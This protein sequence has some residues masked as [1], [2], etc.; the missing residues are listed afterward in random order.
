M[1]GS[2]ARREEHSYA[3][4][5]AHMPS[6]SRCGHDRTYHGDPLSPPAS[7]DVL[8]LH[9]SGWTNP[10]VETF[11]HIYIRVALSLGFHPVTSLALTTRAVIREH[12]VHLRCWKVPNGRISSCV[13]RREGGV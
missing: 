12:R 10:P 1:S 4:V 2:C 6:R 9:D 11:V 3:V 7:R 13:S 5:V 8:Q